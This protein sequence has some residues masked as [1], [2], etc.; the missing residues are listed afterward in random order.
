[1][2]QGTQNT[3][4]AQDAQDA[5]DAQQTQETQQTQQI[6]EQ[7]QSDS[8]AGNQVLGFNPKLR[9]E[10]STPKKPLSFL[11]LPAELRLMVYERL[12]C[13]KI[14]HR[15]RKDGAKLLQQLRNIITNDK[16]A[17]QYWHM[18]DLFPEI[19]ETDDRDDV[20]IEYTSVGIPV[21]LLSTCRLIYNEATRYFNAQFA[22]FIVPENLPRIRCSGQ[23]AVL[24][25]I[26]PGGV[27]SALLDCLRYY[28]HV[29][30]WDF[31]AW[32]STFNGSLDA[33]EMIF[34]RKMAAMLFVCRKEHIPGDCEWY[35]TIFQTDSVTCVNIDVQFTD[36]L[37]A[38]EMYYTTIEQLKK[39]FCACENL[40]SVS[41]WLEGP[42][43]DIK[44]YVSV[45]AGITEEDD[46]AGETMTRSVEADDEIS[47]SSEDE[48]DDAADDEMESDSED[49]SDIGF[50]SEEDSEDDD[51]I[52]V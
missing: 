11:D 45:P 36:P 14:R 3:Q 40:R 44:F 10:P 12:P 5:Q 42:H 33:A 46:H 50:E 37:I 6:L 1:M 20:W 27:L 18:V 38:V 13:D 16:Y 51:V 19:F 17:D 49:E 25:M 21:Q 22:G 39:I 52:S 43:C 31:Y 34:I 24:D 2:T 7:R 41:R 48:S 4:A 32:C 23:L 29:G 30:K 15:I 28:H 26:Y 47:S 35:K 9:N 8:A